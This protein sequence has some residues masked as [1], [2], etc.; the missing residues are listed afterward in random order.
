[1]T[2]WRGW[3]AF[4]AAPVTLPRGLVMVLCFIPCM[5]LTNQIIEALIWYDPTSRGL[6]VIAGL[7][8]ASIWIAAFRGLT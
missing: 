1:M 5:V 3:R 8:I 7:V 4:L 6:W 2:R